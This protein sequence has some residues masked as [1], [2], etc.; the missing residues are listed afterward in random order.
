MSGTVLQPPPPNR[1]PPDYDG[2][3]RE[4]TLLWEDRQRILEGTM[5]TRAM[6]HRTKESVDW[7]VDRADHAHKVVMDEFDKRRA[8]S[9]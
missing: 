4:Y 6:L 9:D 8:N 2:V 3:V 7:L 1:L 5:T